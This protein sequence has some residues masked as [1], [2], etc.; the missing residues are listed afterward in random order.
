MSRRPQIPSPTVGVCVELLECP[1]STV[2]ASP[3][4][5]DPRHGKAEATMSLMTSS[6]KS[7]TTTTSTFGSL[8]VSSQ[9]QPN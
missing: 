8:K 3:R 5:S 6:Q 2:A 1:H 7:P 4:V 9:T